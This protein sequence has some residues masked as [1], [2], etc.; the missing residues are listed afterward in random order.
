MKK[1]IW[2]LLI[3]FPAFALLSDVDKQERFTKNIIRNNG[4]ENS[5]AYWTASGGSFTLATGSS[6][7]VLTGK[8]S[9]IWDASA[10]D[11][12]FQTEA[13]TI[14]KGLYGKNGVVGFKHQN[15]SG[16]A[17]HVLSVFDGSVTIG[18]GITITSSTTPKYD[19]Y[20]FVF[21]SS[22]TI[23]ARVTSTASNEPALS[24]DDFIIADATEVNLSTV[25][26]TTLVASGYIPTTASCAS[27]TRNN[28]ALGAFGSDADCPGPTVE[29]NPGPGTLLTTDSDL[30]KFPMKNLG[31]GCYEVTMEG[32]MG[33]TGGLLSVSI[34]DGTTTAAGNN[35]YSQGTSG[36][37]GYFHVVGIFCY[38]SAG[39]R[40][41][42][43]YGAASSS[44]ITVNIS[45]N[46]RKLY[47]QIKK[48]P[49][50][51][52]Q[53]YT[54]DQSDYGWTAYT[55]TLGAAFGTPTYT[56]FFHRRV[57]DTLE[58]MGAVTIGTVAN[59]TAS[60]SLPG[61]LV[62][63]TT[64]I[65]I[66]NTTSA[67]GARVGTFTALLTQQESPIIT[68]TGTSSSLVYIGFQLN[69]S[70]R[71]T[72]CT[73][74]ANCGIATGA[75]STFHFSVPI[76]GWVTSGRAPQLVNSVVSPVNG[77]MKV[78]SMH[79]AG[80]NPPTISRN[81]GPFSYTSRTGTGGYKWAIAAG[82]CSTVP[83]CTTAC[84]AAAGNA[85]CATYLDSD[86]TN[87][88]TRTTTA[89]WTCSTGAAAGVSDGTE[90]SVICTCQP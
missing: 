3:S 89:L 47:F 34:N 55:P 7:E 23:R 75:H 14:P 51:S 53:A 87:A 73:T 68:A 49:L 35:T 9:A 39:D 42:E 12:T 4:F 62:I 17:T 37:D 70:T 56:S 65:P 81:D 80:G 54:T 28:A 74:A 72:P 79:F 36:Q 27:W 10:A 33:G 43:L 20:N 61:S 90:T 84:K 66:Q 29:Y 85:I 31:P 1:L 50:S 83:N 45:A 15:P 60:V 46:L 11:Q 32:P 16:T 64:K 38:T 19:F 40:T 57:G 67:N 18:G 6:A 88:T 21:P 8:V 48:F 44:T 24:M 69:Q 5:K 2:L 13:I 30:P 71:L 78:F 25:A 58:V 52:Q 26:Q 41:F 76:Q 59:S 63:D 86:C 77:V 22:G 82:T